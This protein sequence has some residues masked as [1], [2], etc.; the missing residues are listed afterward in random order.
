MPHLTL[1]R[2][3]RYL[4]LSLA[5]AAVVVVA[6]EPSW[7]QKE[8]PRERRRVVDRVVAIV[9]D[10]V[11]LQSDLRRRALPALA[12]AQQIAD[13][14][15]RARRIS[16]LYTQ[17]LDEMVSEELILQAAL[18][19][20][21]E[22]DPSELDSAV[23]GAKK[24]FNLD[25]AGFAAALKQ[26]GLTLAQYRN[27]ILRTQLLR[28]RAINQIVRPKVNIT[29][30]DVR[31]RYTQM[32]RRSE[33]ISAVRL[34]HILFRVPDKA[35][36]QVLAAAKE[37]A[38][39]A[40]TRVRGGEP[41]AQVAGAVSQ[42]DATKTTGGELGWFERGSISPEWE[43]VVFSMEQGEVRGPVSGKD[44]LHV[45]FVSE[46]KKSS[47]KSYDELKDE[48]K[49]EL[50]RREMDKQTTTWISGLRKNAHVEIKL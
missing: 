19:A 38:A 16:K 31:N 30:D 47:M 49:D 35:S 10:S 6:A 22:I 4:S 5:V 48:I 24:Q 17:V 7:A 8:K 34:S 12:D 42:D 32:T 50:F 23:D 46:I 9:G 27:E 33:Q 45:F 37:Q 28:L 13:G 26:Q 21:I 43:A 29:D 3:I 41:F 1:H 25:D 11:V 39:Q 15:E 18:E 14:K 44:G 20:K 2:L 36:E 40:I